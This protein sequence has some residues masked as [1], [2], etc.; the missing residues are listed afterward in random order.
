MFDIKVPL[1]CTTDWVKEITT[2]GLMGSDI[3]LINYKLDDIKS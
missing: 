2:I 3:M 1:H